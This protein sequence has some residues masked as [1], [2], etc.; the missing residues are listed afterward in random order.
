MPIGDQF[1]EPGAFVVA[2]GHLA[3][4]LGIPY[5]RAAKMLQDYLKNHDVPFTAA[6][7]AII[8]QGGG[9]GTPPGGDTIYS[10]S[11]YSSGPSAAELAQQK[12]NATASFMSLLRAWGM[13]PTT[14]L[15]KL[16]EQAVE[17]NWNT[18][19]FLEA[20][21]GTTEY[22]EQFPGLDWKNGQTE[23]GYNALYNSFKNIALDIHY[24]L[25]REAFA[26]LNLKGI[27]AKEWS[28]RIASARSIRGN[29][30]LFEEFRQ[31]LVA[32]NLLKPNEDFNAKDLYEFMTSRGTNAWTQIW[33]EASAAAGLAKAGVDVGKGGDISRRNLLH[34]LKNARADQNIGPGQ[35]V[36]IDYVALADD[37]AKFLPL[38]ALYQ[39]GI[40]KKQLVQMRLGAPNARATAERAMR[41]LE[42]WRQR[43]DPGAN[44]QLNQGGLMTGAS[45]NI[46]ATE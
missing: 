32:R 20:V 12:A 31:E 5:V 41:V 22:E 3:E 27:D 26:S 7:N 29:K 45:Q 25:S 2:A 6:I 28:L 36:Q 39:A 33:N 1:V 9:D 18:A 35:M 38:S 17:H 23:A 10:G 30:A 16:I 15:N 4:A 40:T 44:P 46:Q 11:S 8:A 13:E 14:K 43:F 24:K 21:R 34:L 37:I 19:A 42:T